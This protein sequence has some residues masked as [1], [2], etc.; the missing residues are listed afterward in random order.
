M[1]YVLNNF[2]YIYKLCSEFNQKESKNLNAG[3]NKEI[4]IS[5]ITDAA[6]HYIRVSR[7]P[8]Y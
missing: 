2:I 4:N 5:N 6:Q 8:Y 3:R 7:I 1:N